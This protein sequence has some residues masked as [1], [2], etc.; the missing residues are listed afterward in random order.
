[1]EPLL[2]KDLP[3]LIAMLRTAGPELDIAMTTNGV[4]LPRH[5]EA[6]AAA[7][8]DR[9]S[10]SLDAIDE[11]TFAAMTDSNA[12]V[13]QVL[14]GIAA[15]DEAGLGPVK[16]NA[17]V[18]RG[19]NDDQVLEAAPSTADPD[20]W[21]S[22]G[23]AEHIGHP[24]GDVKSAMLGALDIVRYVALR[25]GDAADEFPGQ[26]DLLLGNNLL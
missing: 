16:I 19:V 22:A 18:V 4:L 10:V 21:I 14:D 9:V 25:P 6:L 3:E 13:T 1:G 24:G 15:A 20:T 7:G 23:I 17:V 5:A 11:S 12:T 2:R 8:L 26:P